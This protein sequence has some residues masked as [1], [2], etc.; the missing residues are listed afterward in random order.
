[1][2]DR[3][4]RLEGGKVAAPLL[5][6]WIYTC[7]RDVSWEMRLGAWLTGSDPAL[8]AE[9]LDGLR[10]TG[11]ATFVQLASVE[12]VL[13]GIEGSLSM[14]GHD[15]PGVD[16]TLHNVGIVLFSWVGDGRSRQACSCNSEEFG[17]LDHSEK[18]RN[19]WV[20]L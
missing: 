7:Q 13:A 18:A 5:G 15:I 1:M 14:G 9:L 11:D 3:L 16:L 12:R 10:A 8:L 6:I 4:P 17:K 20:G 2:V 19:D